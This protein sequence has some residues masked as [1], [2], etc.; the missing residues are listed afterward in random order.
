LNRIIKPLERYSGLERYRTPEMSHS[1]HRMT[2]EANKEATDCT[3]RR[4]SKSVKIRANP[5]PSLPVQ[6]LG[7]RRSSR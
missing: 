1:A 5:W 7:C 2:Q 4:R 6:E 3:D